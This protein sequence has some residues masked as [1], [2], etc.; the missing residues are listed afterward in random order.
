[1]GYILFG[2]IVSCEVEN[3]NVLGIEESSPGQIKTD[4]FCVQRGQT[5][6]RA[7][8]KSSTGGQAL[9][10]ELDSADIWDPE[11]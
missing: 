8:G 6:Q 5:A 4:R 3:K 1:M 2:D 9:Y 11:T 7:R 10:M